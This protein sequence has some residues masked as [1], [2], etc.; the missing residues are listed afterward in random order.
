MNKESIEHIKN[1]FECMALELELGIKPQRTEMRCEHGRRD[2]R[3]RSQTTEIE[4]C[5][6]VVNLDTTK[7]TLWMH[8]TPSGIRARGELLVKQIRTAQRTQSRSSSCIE[9]DR[10]KRS[11]RGTVG[12]QTKFNPKQMEDWLLEGDRQNAREYWEIYHPDWHMPRIRRSTSWVRDHAK[13][14]TKLEEM[15]R[16]EHEFACDLIGSINEHGGL[17]EKQE[18]VAVRL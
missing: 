17:T 2:H 18:A 10:A 12:G 13:L 1:Q 15:G 6:L 5:R 3:G 4:W 8:C 11:T 14:V 16:R 9:V 7:L